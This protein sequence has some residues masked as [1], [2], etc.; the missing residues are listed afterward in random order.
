MHRKIALTF[1]DG[2]RPS[3]TYRLARMLRKHGAIGTFF[4]VG[5][6]AAKNPEVVRQLAREGHEIANHTWSHSELKNMSPVDFADE[7]EGTRYLIRELTGRDSTIFRTPGSTEKFIRN[8]FVVP[9]HY[10]LILWD[11]HSLDQEKLSAA[12][13]AERVESLAK[14]G[15]IV[16]MHNGIRPTVEALDILLPRLKSLGFEFMTVSEILKYRQ[17]FMVSSVNKAVIRG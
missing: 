16:L 5:Q 15:D 11:V 4:I 2:P 12:Q 17:K 7:I 8:H 1:D 3:P 6:V 13:I 14:D 9:A 10:T